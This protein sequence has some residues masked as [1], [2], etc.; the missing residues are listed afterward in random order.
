MIKEAVNPLEPRYEDLAGDGF[1]R[2]ARKLFL[3]TRPKF[4]TASVLPVLVG[5]AWGATIA[6]QF[7]LL[8]AVIALLATA[9]VHGASNVIN[10]VG[11]EITGTDRDN[12][13]RIYPYT[14]GSR[15][16]QNRIMT[17]PEMNR[18]GWTLIAVASLLGL[19]LATMRGPWVIALGIAGIFIAWSYSAP[20]LQLSGKGVGEFFLMIAFG[21]L[22]AGGAAWLQSGVFDLATVLMAIPLGIWVML[23]LW[24]NEVPDRKADAANGK[25]T[26][27][28][29]LGLDGA[30]MGYRLL[31]VAAFAAIVALVV[32]G[33]MPWW[34]TLGALLVMAGGFKAASGIGEDV[35]R[36]ALTQSIEMT[37]GLQAA[38]SILLFVGALFAA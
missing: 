23:I 29:R 3:A 28:V 33:A 2:R 14:G 37:I 5:T 19:W 13:E 31:H 9:L 16:I 27:V 17:A 32:L 34:V 6:G 24:I 36:I 25:R 22:P 15:F 7:D 21:L 20:S 1:G 18:W 4:L 11:D 30:R 8:V 26:L 10:D 35:S 12:V 38:G